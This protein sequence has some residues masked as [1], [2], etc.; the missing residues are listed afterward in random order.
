MHRIIITGAGGFLGEALT[1]KCIDNGKE[2]IAISQEFGKS[3]PKSSLITK[4]ETEIESIDTILSNVPRLEYDGFYHFAWKGVN[5]PYKSDV[6]TQIDN[7]KMS[8]MCAE[9]AYKLSCRKFLCSGTVAE[10]AIESLPDLTMT[11]GGMAY[12]VAKY[13][14]HQLIDYYCKNVGMKYVW[15]Q[16]SNIYGPHNK[17]G[18][19]ISYTLSQLKNGNEALFGPCLQPYDFIYVDDVLE[20]I[21]RLGIYDT[22]RNFYFLGSGSPRVLKNYLSSIGEIYKKSDLIKFGARLDDGIMYS[23]DMFDTSALIEDIGEYVTASFED[24][25]KY[26]IMNF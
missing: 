7:I 11:N 15:M 4:I 2:V 10:R 14:A 26:T 23:M 12:S 19:L 9:A 24:H 17:T 25:I 13:C 5:G 21:Y 20:A 6:L 16:L 8:M 3:F 22:K 18:N 1:R